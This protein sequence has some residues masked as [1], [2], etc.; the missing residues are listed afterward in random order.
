[1]FCRDLVACL[2]EADGASVDA[3]YGVIFNEVDDRRAEVVVR[4]ADASVAF[5]G[6]DVYGGGVEKWRLGSLLGKLGECHWL[7]TQTHL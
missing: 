2:H 7:K 5:G 3:Q 1:M 4:G 6:L